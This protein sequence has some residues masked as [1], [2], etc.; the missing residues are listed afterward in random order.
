MA[1]KK[2]NEFNDASFVSKVT[3][4]NSAGNS[5]NIIPVNLCNLLFT[6][7]AKAN[8]NA[9]ELKTSGGYY[10][11][12]GATNCWEWSYLLVFRISDA[13]I[14]QLDIRNNAGAVQIRTLANETWSAW[15]VL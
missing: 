15:K 11:T 7:G 4:I 8:A 5:V 1:D 2:M 3:A 14:I 13:N 12:S 6:G 10:I 9:D